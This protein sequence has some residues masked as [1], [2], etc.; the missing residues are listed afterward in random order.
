[1]HVLSLGVRSGRTSDLL[2]AKGF[3]RS[4]YSISLIT[5]KPRRYIQVDL[6]VHVSVSRPAPKLHAAIPNTSNHVSFA[7][8]SICDKCS[9][10]FRSRAAQWSASLKWTCRESHIYHHEGSLEYLIV[11]VSRPAVISKVVSGLGTSIMYVCTACT[12][13]CT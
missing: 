6:A 5:G 8:A 4:T 7:P 1:M 9:D 11:T 13:E 10:S 3:P 12:V 2:G